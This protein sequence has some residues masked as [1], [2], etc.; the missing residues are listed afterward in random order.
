MITLE[1]GVINKR[2]PWGMVD[3]RNQERTV[4]FRRWNLNESYEPGV[5]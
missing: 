4:L 3:G 2:W 5:L 1:Y